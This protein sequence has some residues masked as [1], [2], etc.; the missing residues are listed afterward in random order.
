MSV[1]LAA[2][3]L[4]KDT[5]SILAYTY[6]LSKYWQSQDSVAQLLYVIDY[7]FTPP[8]YMLPYFEQ[9]R[10]KN[11]QVL[12]KWSSDIEKQGVHSASEIQSGRL[13]ETF[14]S[15][16]KKYEANVMVIGHKSHMLRTSSSEKLIRT[17][18]VPTFVVRGKQAN[19]R[20]IGEVRIKRILCAVD[21]SPD[22]KRALDTAR[23]LA[24]KCGALL[25]ILN[26]VDTK[27][28]KE[29]MALWKELDE[30][31]A[32]CGRDLTAEAQAALTSFA[33]SSEDALVVK[34]GVPH[35]EITR[36]ADEI[37]TDLI[38]MGARGVSRF[39]GLFLGS[40]SESV[41]KTS[42]CPVLV[43]N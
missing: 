8:A 12:D 41:V 22:A 23:R 4:G 9:E 25:E 6:W 33:G 15:A 17:L 10:I 38:V 21:M 35:E 32:S 30:Q 11:K 7:S 34:T 40:V 19:A 20:K 3:D 26:V 39:E 18:V 1:V 36:Y 13:V 31:Q 16:I 29:C 27:M 2:V 28:L 14:A 24:R 37:C 42:P 5:E 43:V